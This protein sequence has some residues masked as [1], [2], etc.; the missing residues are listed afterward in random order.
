MKENS[1]PIFCCKAN[2][3]MLKL[4]RGDEMK[5]FLILLFIVCVLACFVGCGD[6][7]ENNGEK[8]TTTASSSVGAYS[9][10]DTGADSSA[11]E[12]IDS[13]VD[14]SVDSSVAESTDSSVAESTDSSVDESVDSSVAESTDSSVDESVDSSV[15]ESTDSSVAESTDSSVAESTDSSVAESTDSSQEDDTTVD[16]G[17]VEEKKDPEMLIEEC[18]KGE[19]NGVINL[20]DDTQAYTFYFAD[21]KGALEGYVAIGQCEDGIFEI[22]DAVIPPY[23]TKIEAYQGAELVWS[24][25]IPSEYLLSDEELYI[26]GV[27]SDVHYDRYFHDEVDDAITS[28]DKALDY[29]ESVGVKFVGIAG[30][31]TSNGEDS[32]FEKYNA[33]IS[34]RPFPIYTVTGNHDV[35]TIASGVW[36]EQITSGIVGATF[37]PNGLDFVYVIDE[38][39]G[40]VFVF[41]NQ[42]RWEYNEEDSSLLDSEQLVWLEEVL[43][44]YKDETV[45]LFFHTLL[46]CPDG[47]KHTGVGNIMNPGGY[48]YPLPYTYGNEDE[49][50]FRRLMAEYKNVIYFSG[51]SHWMFEMDVYSEYTNYS[52]FDGE[53]C[54]MIHVPSV[55]EPRYIEDDDTNRTGKNGQNS[56]GWVA[57]DYGDTVIFVPVDFITGVIYTDKLIKITQ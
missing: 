22:A 2:D 8:S 41:L 10:T 53:Y 49:V 39:G 29:L 7:T 20:Y 9:S 46:C 45:Y 35:T 21:G 34:S 27:L 51:H 17:E 15:D 24:F 1:T 33:E 31:I 32:A 38:M 40:D 12:S 48:T 11:N 19:L 56:Q 42:M 43:E 30:D 16:S 25:D 52:N 47:E 28:F 4:K 50:E 14:E 18:D 54:H 44:E 6:V 23:A 5:R 37:A 55:T 36:S 57:Y 3:F 13:S 26:F